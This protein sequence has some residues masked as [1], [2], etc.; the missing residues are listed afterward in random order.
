[1][2]AFE[3]PPFRAGQDNTNFPASLKKAIRRFSLFLQTHKP[4]SYKLAN[5]RLIEVF[6]EDPLVKSEHSRMQDAIDV[7]DKGDLL[8][9]LS[10]LLTTIS[11]VMARS[12]FSKARWF[13]LTDERKVLK[14]VLRLTVISLGI[15]ALVEYASGYPLESAYMKS[16]IFADEEPY[17]QRIDEYTNYIKSTALKK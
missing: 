6:R 13:I 11:V 12:H 14:P 4:R 9:S 5:T 16:Q 17:W 8:F 2:S 1:M 10:F 3:E 7:S 15:A